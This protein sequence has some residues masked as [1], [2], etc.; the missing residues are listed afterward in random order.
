MLK[1]KAGIYKLV[2]EWKFKSRIPDQISD[3]IYIENTSEGEFVKKNNVKRQQE[4]ANLIL[5]Q[6]KIKH[7]N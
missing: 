1:N 3:W 4:Y 7:G 5:F 6:I 2:Y